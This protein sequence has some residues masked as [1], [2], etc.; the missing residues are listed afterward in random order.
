MSY[1]HEIFVRIVSQV[2]SV[3]A[4]R[5]PKYKLRLK[6]L[7]P[8]L[9]FYTPK[10]NKKSKPA[11]ETSWPLLAAVITNENVENVVGPVLFNVLAWICGF[12]DDS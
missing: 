4:R 5:F 12:S 3:D 9:A 10:N 2:E 6:K 11:F 7:Y 1:L 8:H